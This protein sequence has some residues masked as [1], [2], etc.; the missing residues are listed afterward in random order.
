MD[1]VDNNQR[2]VEQEERELLLR[3]LTQARQRVHLAEHLLGSEREDF[4][5]LI[6]E[7]YPKLGPAAIGRA[8]GLSRQRV[9][10]FYDAALKSRNSNE[11]A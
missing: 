4:L 8:L 10:Q 3:E 11:A 2:S 9:Y 7:A 1:P 6:R 5:T